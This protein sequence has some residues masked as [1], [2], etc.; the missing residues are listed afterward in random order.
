MRLLNMCKSN[1]AFLEAQHPDFFSELLLHDDFFSAVAHSAFFSVEFD[2]LSSEEQDFL[3]L[4]E[5]QHFSDLAFAFF[6]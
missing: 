2:A 3:S 1:Y 5:E 6:A 4:L